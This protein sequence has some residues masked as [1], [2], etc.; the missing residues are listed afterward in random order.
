VCVCVWE[1]EQER[2][3][4]AMKRGDTDRLNLISRVGQNRIYAPY[5]TVYLVISLPK[6]PYIH[7][8]YMVLANPTYIPSC[9]RLLLSTQTKGPGRPLPRRGGTVPPINMGGGS[10]KSTLKDATDTNQK[11]SNKRPITL[12]GT[13]SVPPTGEERPAVKN[14]T[15]LGRQW[16]YNR[17]MNPPC[18]IKIKSKSQICEPR[19]SRTAEDSQICDLRLP[20]TIY[21]ARARIFRSKQLLLRIVRKGLCHFNCETQSLLLY[22]WLQFSRHVALMPSQLRHTTPFCCTLSYGSLAV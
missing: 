10:T 3:A 20:F 16:L 15:E 12:E 21:H 11:S 7:R 18:R 17:F 13:T 22:K 9:S 5:M 8:I 2:P 14:V 19:V 4:Q 6:I 1:K